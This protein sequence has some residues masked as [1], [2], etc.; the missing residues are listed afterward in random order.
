MN[1]HQIK[2]IYWIIE[3]QL[4]NVD[5]ELEG[6]RKKCANDTAKALENYLVGKKDGLE[7]CR[8]KLY[9]ALYPDGIG[10]ATK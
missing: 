4:E 7:L 2:C 9:L 3:K 6:V 1:E 8:D 5:D 10:N